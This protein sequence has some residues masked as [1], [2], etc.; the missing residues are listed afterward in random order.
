MCDVTYVEETTMPFVRV[1][2][3]GPKSLD[4]KR[5]LLAGARAAIVEEFGV[6]DGRVVVRVSESA[7]EDVDLPSCRTERMTVLDVL[8]LAGRT[9]ELKTA[10]VA[11]LREKYAADPG[12]EPSEVVVSFREATPNDLHTLP[13]RTGV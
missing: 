2:I 9:P 13:G 10:M 1:D 4:Y 8:M 12:I 5:A 11:A 6:D 3:V 7:P